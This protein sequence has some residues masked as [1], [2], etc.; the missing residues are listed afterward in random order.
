MHPTQQHQRQTKIRRNIGGLFIA[1]YLSRKKGTENGRIPI[2][3]S[4]IFDTFPLPTNT[5]QGI[6]QIK[7]VMI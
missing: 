7:G 1:S 6:E 2:H 4:I 3:N 5:T